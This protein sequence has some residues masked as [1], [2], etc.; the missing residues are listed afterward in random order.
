MDL[1]FFDSALVTLTENGDVVLALFDGDPPPVTKSR[2]VALLSC[3]KETA[4]A[5][6]QSLGSVLKP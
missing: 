3:R 6:T 4:A 2:C 5:L 1:I